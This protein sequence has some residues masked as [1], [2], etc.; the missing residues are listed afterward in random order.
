L[1]ELF[2]LSYFECVAW[3]SSLFKVLGYFTVLSV[4]RLHWMRR[5]LINM[6]ELVEWELPSESEIL[7][8]LLSITNPTWPDL[9]SNFGHC[10]GKLGT[11]CTAQLHVTQDRNPYWFHRLKH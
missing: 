1:E 10:S 9:W 4:S 7:D 11:R 3:E 8:A 2:L 5:E 6:E